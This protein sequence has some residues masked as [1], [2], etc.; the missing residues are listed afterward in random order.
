MS[1]FEFL[2][3]V[4]SV[5]SSSYKEHLM[6]SFLENWLTENNIPYYTDEFGNVYATKKTNL[7][8]NQF[9]PC[10]VS[11]TD[12]VH[13]ISNINILEK[14]LPDSDKNL[15]L[16]LTSVDDDGEP[17]GIGG[18]DKCGVYICLR[19]LRELPNVKAA[20]FVSEEIGCKGSLNADPKFFEDVGYAIQFDAP[21]NWMVTYT[22]MGIELFDIKSEFFDKCHNVLTEDFNH[23]KN[24]LRH[25]YTDVYALRK[26]FDFACINISCGYYN[27]HKLDE[28]VVVDDVENSHDVGV[29]MIEQLGYNKYEFKKQANT[30]FIL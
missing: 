27:Y 16:S 20:F 8:E 11:H 9:F 29:K 21:E 13:I 10:V 4:L 2:K 7:Q 1:N 17:N 15:K 6:I 28:Y 30:R 22:C 18:D 19:L 14:Q 24:Y 23:K 26:K 3:Q 25:P 5:P 12:T